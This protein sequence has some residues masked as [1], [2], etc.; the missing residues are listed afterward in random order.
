[1]INDL[2]ISI[3]EF[4]EAGVARFWDFSQYRLCQELQIAA[5][6]TYYTNSAFARRCCDCCD[7]I[8][9]YYE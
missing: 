3:Q 6:N 7:D 4:S 9:A 5:R 8:R 1:M 2:P